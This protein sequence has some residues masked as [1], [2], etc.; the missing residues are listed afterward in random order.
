MN[1]TAPKVPVEK[2]RLY[3]ARAKAKKDQIKHLCGRLDHEI[4]MGESLKS[5]EWLTK[6]AATREEL[7]QLDH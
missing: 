4:Q 1:K 3:R 7:R 2:Q 5:S 6:A